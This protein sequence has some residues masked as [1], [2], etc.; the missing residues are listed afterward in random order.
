M[1]GVGDGDDDDGNRY[2]KGGSAADRD[3]GSAEP[4]NRPGWMRKKDSMPAD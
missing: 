2:V 3:L 1:F 4:A